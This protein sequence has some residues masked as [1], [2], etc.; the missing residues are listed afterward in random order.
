[1]AH[2][3]KAMLRQTKD[4]VNQ[5]TA[6]EARVREATSND[7]WVPPQSLLQEIAESTYKREELKEVMDMMFKRMNDSGKVRTPPRP[8]SRAC[9]PTACFCVYPCA[10]C[11]PGA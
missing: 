3:M 8:S 4:F 9:R 11:S 7:P 1:M 10:R 5:H 6:A 2:T